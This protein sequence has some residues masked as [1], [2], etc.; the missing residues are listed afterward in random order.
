MEDVVMN[1]G[2]WAIQD[3]VMADAKGMF[4]NLECCYERDQGTDFSID[5]ALG[6]WP[7]SNPIA[8][9]SRGLIVSD[10][11]YFELDQMKDD[12]IDPNLGL[13][14]STSQP[15]SDFPLHDELVPANYL[16][17]APPTEQKSLTLFSSLEAAQAAVRR[18]VPVITDQTL[19]QTTEEHQRL[20]VDLKKAMLSTT[21]VTDNDKAKKAFSNGQYSDQ[22]IELACWSLLVSL[23]VPHSSN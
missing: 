23:P 17:T 14:P 1:D 9:I 13:W 2:D 18:K 15:I 21:Y 12:S 10:G 8:E 16:G 3:W 7:D 11:T 5:P 6:L 4:L 22:E 20:I 19:P